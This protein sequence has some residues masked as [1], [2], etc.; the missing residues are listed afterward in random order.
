M[1]KSI[2]FFLDDVKHFWTVVFVSI[3]IVS[4]ILAALSNT[5]NTL[6]FFEYLVTP[7]GIIF[8]LIVIFTVS[9]RFIVVIIHYVNKLR[10]HTKK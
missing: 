5:D 1:L 2:S 10:E 4:M 3:I 9:L 8:L 6:N 7:D